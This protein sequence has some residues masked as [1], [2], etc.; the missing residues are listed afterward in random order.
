MSRRTHV[1]TDL[2]LW[3]LLKP[4]SYCGCTVRVDVAMKLVIYS[5]RRGLKSIMHP[6]ICE[7][8]AIQPVESAALIEI[9]SPKSEFYC[10]AGWTARNAIYAMVQ[11]RTRRTFMLHVSLNAQHKCVVFF[12]RSASSNARTLF[13]SLM[14]KSF[15][16]FHNLHF[17]CLPSGVLFK[18]MNSLTCNIT[19]KFIQLM[20]MNSIVALFRS[21]SLFPPSRWFRDIS[22]LISPVIYALCGGKVEWSEAK[23]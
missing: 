2:R 4:F 12:A 17:Y 15:V 9:N 13:S 3:K 8:G 16:P 22:R 18:A 11:I 19:S 5:A 1:L 21:A 20:W 10:D 6:I 23:L 7:N 14:R